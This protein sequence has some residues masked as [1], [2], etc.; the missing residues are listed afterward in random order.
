MLLINDQDAWALA[1]SWHCLYCLKV[2][3]RMIYPGDWDPTP[4]Q[5]PNED[6]VAF[7]ITFLFILNQPC[8]SDSSHSLTHLYSTHMNRLCSTQ[9]TN[10]E[11]LI[12]C[13][14]CMGT[15]VLFPLSADKTEKIWWHSAGKQSYKVRIRNSAIS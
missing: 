1:L 8:K 7:N 6:T 9:Q 13:E 4:R 5:G 11:L 14:G 2:A 10:L 12:R 15:V 3:G